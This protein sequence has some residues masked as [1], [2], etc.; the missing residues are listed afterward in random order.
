MVELNAAMASAGQSTDYKMESDECIYART[1][2]LIRCRNEVCS[3]NAVD[4]YVRVICS[5]ANH[6]S[7]P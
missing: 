3:R 7:H 1:A 6:E 4:D 2:A 5:L